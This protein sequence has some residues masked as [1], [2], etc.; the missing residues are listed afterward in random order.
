MKLG[1]IAKLIDGKLNGDADI[2]ITNIASIENAKEGDITWASHPRYKKWLNSTSATCV[3]VSKNSIPSTK[4]G[5]P[6][7]IG[8]DNPDL[9]AYK[10]LRVF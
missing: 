6:A 9:A 2:L 8:V 7:T 5:R 1:Y 3:V 4:N 10:L